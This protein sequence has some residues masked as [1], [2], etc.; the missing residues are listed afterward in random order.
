MGG[1]VSV[2]S[3]GS[4][5]RVLE[6]HYADLGASESWLGRVTWPLYTCGLHA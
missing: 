2:C 5:D 6:L 1:T 4:K 3:P